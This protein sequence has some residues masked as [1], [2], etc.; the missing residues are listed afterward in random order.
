MKPV[1]LHTHSRASDGTD[2]PAALVAKAAAAGLGCIALTDHDS[3]AG[4]PEAVAAG[5]ALGL[6][7]VRGCEIS[8]STEYGEMHILGLWLPAQAPKLEK[9]LAEM[10]LGRERRNR[11]MLARLNELGLEIRPEDLGSHANG[12]IGRPHIARALL[13]KGYV[14]SIGEAFRLYLV[15]GR[16]AWEPRRLPKPGPVVE[17][18]A[19]LGACVSLAHPFLLRCPAPWLERQIAALR[20]SG[21]CAIE[22]W[23]SAHSEAQ[24]EQAR[25]L[26]RRYGLRLTG[27]SD[28][29]GANKP[30]VSLGICGSGQIPG[31]ILD[32]LRNFA[33]G[34]L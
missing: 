5:K 29:H 8:T 16:P 2:S 22:A 33:T 18:M 15:K 19:T 24:I 25:H 20:E 31:A 14:D 26:A 1:D 9:L 21:L 10:R 17:L 7:V 11:T 27:G 13:A 34:Q 6:P 4:V 32:G 23:H 28:Y 12:S 3:V 30:G